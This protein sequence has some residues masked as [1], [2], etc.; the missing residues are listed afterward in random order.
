MSNGMRSCA[1][2][3]SNQGQTSNYWLQSN[4]KRGRQFMMP[5]PVCRQLN[6]FGRWLLF[7]TSMLIAGTA[8]AETGDDMAAW[9]YLKHPNTSL[10][11][12]QSS[13]ACP[14][15]ICPGL[16]NG[17]Y[18]P[19]V[20]A[21]SILTG[22]REIFINRKLGECAYVYDDKDQSERVF[23]SSD[24]MESLDRAMMSESN[25]E[26]SVTTAALSMKGT[27]NS[28]TSHSSSM[29]STFH[30]THMD[31]LA[32]THTIEFRN[33][34]DCSLENNIAQDV[35]KNFTSLP[36][37]NETNVAASSSWTPYVNFLK[38]VGSHVMM[39]QLI[40]SRFQQWESSTSTKKDIAKELQIKACA[41]V[42][43]PTGGGWSVKSCG[44]YSEKEMLSSLTLSTDSKQVI[45]GSST[46]ARNELTKA[47]NEENLSRFIDDA[48]QGNEAIRYTYKPI[49]LVFSE[50]FQHKCQVSG[51]G[52]ED[53]NNLQR[54][55]TL[56]AAYDGWLAVDCPEEKTSN[57]F[58][59]QAMELTQPN[60]MGIR[61]YQC[62]LAGLG[63]KVDDDC[64]L[65]C[66]GCLSTVC[67]GKSCIENGPE[68]PQ[69]NFYRDK[70]RQSKKGSHDSDVVNKSCYY[71]SAYKARCHFDA[72]APR[73]IYK[74]Q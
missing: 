50:I 5:G 70:V 74:Q 54:A 33:N 60:S 59:M 64:H 41:Q 22:G 20:N 66:S 18:L 57:G 58:T 68:I 73:Q 7:F 32:I 51:Q 34:A 71:K 72:V 45:R 62:T 30:S 10:S 67:Y 44:A 63:C 1:Q 3:A 15:N 36:I 24:S 69:T 52:S 29:T 26:A 43:G 39:Q 23:K 35:M 21:Q 48:D 4:F 12:V 38:S 65:S 49:Y 14:N 17:F 27:I 53:C 8:F 55:V 61:N 16:G 46:K 25:L 56:Q 40:G 11:T 37:L 13:P 19:D 9:K 28:L 47:V 6:N 2:G 42:E 31:I